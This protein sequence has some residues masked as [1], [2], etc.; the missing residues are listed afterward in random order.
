MHVNSSYTPTEDQWSKAAFDTT[1]VATLKHTPNDFKTG[2]EAI[3]GT[4]LDGDAALATMYMEG[5][6]NFTGGMVL[7]ARDQSALFKNSVNLKFNS[8]I[9]KSFVNSSLPPKWQEGSWN[10]Q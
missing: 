9:M 2:L 5:S 7:D 8:E 6:F 3:N 10:A 4:Y 1:L